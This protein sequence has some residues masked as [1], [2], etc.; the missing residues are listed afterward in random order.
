MENRILMVNR[1]T[2][3]ITGIKKVNGASAAHLE[4]I[5]DNTSLLVTGENMEVRKLDVEAGVIEVTGRIDTIKYADK[6]EKGSF[7]K[8]ILKWFY[9][10]HFLNL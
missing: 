8:R 9:M 2:L 6:K 1:A 4:L 7:I 10:K 5:L 3:E